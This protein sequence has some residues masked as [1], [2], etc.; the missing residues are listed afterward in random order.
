MSQS[1]SLKQYVQLTNDSL[2]VRHSPERRVIERV[3]S[4]CI[5]STTRQD[6]VVSTSI[7]LFTSPCFLSFDVLCMPFQQR[8]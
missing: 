3:S 2:M 8:P 5:I 4:A 6:A 7:H 1:K